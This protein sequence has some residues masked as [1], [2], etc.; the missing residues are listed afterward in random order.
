MQFA[1]HS[2]AQFGILDGFLDIDEKKKYQKKIRWKKN[3]NEILL[4]VHSHL[5][6]KKFNLISRKCAQ[7]ENI[8]SKQNDL[9]APMYV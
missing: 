2:H 4:K 1:T 7:R 8:C 9:F 5:R 6:K 3:Y